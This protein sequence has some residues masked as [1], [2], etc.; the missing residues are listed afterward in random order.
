MKRLQRNIDCFS[1]SLPQYTTV[2]QMSA[3]RKAN[4]RKSATV[5]RVKSRRRL[6]RGR[7]IF[8]KCSTRKIGSRYEL[9]ERG[10]DRKRT[11]EKE[12]K[13]GSAYSRN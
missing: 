6:K 11:G 1:V 12:R 10:R 2:R 9:R 5:R 13:N 8:R 3:L 7:R 4:F